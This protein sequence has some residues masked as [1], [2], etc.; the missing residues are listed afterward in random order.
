MSLRRG[1][2]GLV[3]ARQ[4]AQGWV[5][6]LLLPV[7]G[8]LN[9]WGAGRIAVIYA[10]SAAACCALAATGRA[11]FTDL[12]VYR[13]GGEAVLH[14][15]SLYGVRYFGLPFT[16][17]PFAAVIF[18]PVAALPWPVAATLLTMAS[19][20]TVPMVLYLALRLPPVPSWLSSPDAWRLALAIGAAAIWLE[21]IRTTFGYG[22]VDLFIAGGIL[23]DLTRPGNSRGQ[24]MATGLAAGFKLT[25][26]I[27]VIYL[28]VTR[29]YRAAATAAVTFAATVIAGFALMPRTSAHFWDITFLNPQRVSRVQNTENQSLLGVMARNLHT[30]D[31][32]GVWLGVAVVVAVAGLALA[33]RAQ[34]RGDEALGFSLCALTGLLVSPISWTHHWVIAV[35]ALL[36]AGVSLCR[37]DTRKR[38]V[39]IVGTA[40][41]TALAVTGWANLAR[42]VSDTNWLHLPATSIFYSEIYVV[43]GLAAL[44]LAA[45]PGNQA[46][47]RAAVAATVRRSRRSPARRPSSPPRGSTSRARTPPARCPRRR[48]WPPPGSPGLSTGS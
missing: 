28:L 27:F 8:R 13:L 20:I 6:G 14:G 36:L 22:Q 38:R 41:I 11:D 35:P 9:G 31:L 32:L 48:G 17:P 23:Y 43:A 44:G 10:L 24:G 19:A 1:D 25:P 16:Y 12:H 4:P 21:P 46:T 5:G 33:A 2:A 37:D 15:T 47:P 18:A 30:S 29:R 34:R 45:Y 26:A 7:R 3:R 39:R 40:A 42:E